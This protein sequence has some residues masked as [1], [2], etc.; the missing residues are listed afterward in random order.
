[1]DEIECFL[2]ELADA[3]N[4]DYRIF[5]NPY[6]TRYDIP[7]WHGSGEISTLAQELLDKYFSNDTEETK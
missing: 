2:R 7:E 6:G 5:Y 1:M 3:S 4:W